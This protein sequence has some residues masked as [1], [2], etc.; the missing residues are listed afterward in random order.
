[1]ATSLTKTYNAGTGNI[2]VIGDQ[3][4]LKK[5]QL[6][7]NEMDASSR[8]VEAAFRR[9]SK[10][11]V[12]QARMNARFSA[13]RTGVLWKS[14][15]FVRSARLKSLFWIGPARGRKQK[16][17]GWYGHFIEAGTPVREKRG[18]IKPVRYMAR[19]FESTKNKVRYAIVRE[20]N[21]LIKKVAAK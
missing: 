1:M 5:L 4:L 13:K 8:Q 2:E 20:L 19:A 17:D 12:N 9:A 14:I 11:M 7:Y 18:R 15:R 21:I 3:L 10:P 16:Y 6:L